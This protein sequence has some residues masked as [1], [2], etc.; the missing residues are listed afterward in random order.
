MPER[1]ISRRALIRRSASAAGAAFAVNPAFGQ[2]PAIVT[3]RRFRAWIGRGTGQG[4]TTLQEVTLRPISGRQVVVRTEACNLCYSNAGAVLG[5]TTP[6]AITG[7][8]AGG[9]NLSD[10][11]VIQG[12]GG[13]GVVEAVGQDVRGGRGGGRGGVGGDTRGGPL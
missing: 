1:H 7:T 2:A 3:G 9:R 11:A 13:V 4:R 5:L 6:A 8:N 10:M 12:H